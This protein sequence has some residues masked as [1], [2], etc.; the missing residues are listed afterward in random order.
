MDLRAAGKPRSGCR[1]RREH[2]PSGDLAREAQCNGAAAAVRLN[3][4]CGCLP[5]RLAAEI[6]DDA[7]VAAEEPV[8]RPSSDEDLAVLLQREARSPGVERDDPS[9][10]EARIEST[11]RQEPKD[12]AAT[13]GVSRDEDLAIAL[14]EDGIRREL[15]AFDLRV[16]VLPE[17]RV[18]EPVGTVAGNYGKCLLV[19]LSGPRHDDLPVLEG[20]R[21][22]GQTAVGQRR[23]KCEI[24]RA[25][26]LVPRERDLSIVVRMA[27]VG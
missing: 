11:V 19:V 1:R 8:E 21:A 9:S 3:K 20:R 26:G 4:V 24:D 14:R 13:V 18:N 10:A 6:R 2:T 12:S 15:R 17:G 22:A 25:V 16:T 23:V 5:D 7:I 27:T